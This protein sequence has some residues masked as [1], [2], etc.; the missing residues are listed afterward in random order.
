MSFEDNYLEINKQSW[1]KRTEVHLT[2][3]FY[4]VA[5]FL[6]GRSSLNDIELNLLGD[7]E[8]KDILHLQCHFGQDAISLSRKGAKVTGVDLSD[9]AIQSA[10]DLAQKAGTDTAFICCD[11]YDSPNHIDRKF[12]IVYTSYGVIGW[13]PDMNRWAKVISHFLRPGGKLVF[14]EFHP[15]V[16]MF[17]YDFQKVEYNYF[18]SNAIIETE[19]GTYGDRDADI[20]IQ[21]VS[22][23]HSISEVVNSLIQ[24]GLTILSLDE[25]DYSPYNC[26]KNTIESEPGKFRINHLGNKIPMLYTL[27]AEKK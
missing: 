23:N 27:V 24:N 19:S 25:F 4:D 9:L 18:N 20:Q 12:D 7:I 8:G 3:D 2:S 1:N 15:V 17:D 6:K 5:G 22:W 10:K 26:F 21:D 11:V 16:W 14:A 13:L